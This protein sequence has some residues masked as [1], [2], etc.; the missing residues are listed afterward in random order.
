MATGERWKDQLVEQSEPCI[1][2]IHYVHCLMWVQLVAFQSNYSSNIC[3]SWI[4]DYH[5]KYNSNEKFEI[6]R[7]LPKCDAETSSEH[8]L[9]RK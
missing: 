2:V 9:L 7:E 4:T 5:D 8:I 1:A 6:F 3:G